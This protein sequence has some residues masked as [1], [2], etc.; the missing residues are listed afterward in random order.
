M[1]NISQ[2][3]FFSAHELTKNMISHDDLSQQQSEQSL[4][5]FQNLKI[6]TVPNIQDLMIELAEERGSDRGREINKSEEDPSLL[7]DIHEAL[8]KYLLQG[9]HEIWQTDSEQFVDGWK[10]INK[11]LQSGRATP[12]EFHEILQKS[13]GGD[14]SLGLALLDNLIIK[15]HLN[16]LMGTN[17]NAASLRIDYIYQNQTAIGA[18]INS[19]EISSEFAQKDAS[20]VLK[21]QKFYQERID[22]RGGINS[23]LAALIE[24]FGVDGFERGVSFCEQAATK[25]INAP[26]PSMEPEKLHSAIQ[27]LQLA[28]LFHQI[29]EEVSKTIDRLAKRSLDILGAALKLDKNKLTHAIIIFLDKPHTFEQGVASHIKGQDPAVAIPFL[30]DLKQIIAVLPEFFFAGR[31]QLSR[32]MIPMQVELDK[33][34]KLEDEA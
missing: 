18:G 11:Y 6:G 33:W 1:T 4:G 28:K 30:N 29:K 20:E 13:C 10:E 21:L 15:G 3:S 14:K 12:Q 2:H 16:N 5:S 9:V 23:A 31:D 32:I 17:A 34:A 25:D 8:A 24:N 19:F 26:R 27:S 7:T 22:N